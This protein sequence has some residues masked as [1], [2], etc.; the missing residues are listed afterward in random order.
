[1]Y[2]TKKAPFFSNFKQVR[3]A[4]HQ[5]S[6]TEPK[7]KYI[8]SSA[9]YH[10]DSLLFVTS[11]SELGSRVVR[12]ESWAVHAESWAVPAVISTSVLLRVQPMIPQ[13]QPYCPIWNSVLNIDVV[14]GAR[15]APVNQ[16]VERH[17]SSR[18]PLWSVSI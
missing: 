1:M 4:W 9:M 12:T 5:C 10:G 11:F 2:N 16:V 8:H 17:L 13:V 14:H 15:L 18:D 7:Y 3:L 6:F